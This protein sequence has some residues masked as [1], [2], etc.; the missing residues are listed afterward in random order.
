M[1]RYVGLM[2]GTSLDAIDAALLNL[3]GGTLSLEAH[4]SHPIA[5][6]L[7]NE[8]LALCEGTEGEID[9]AGAADRQL[10]AALG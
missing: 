4:H 9:R 10:G 5:P 6:A 3:D 2:S 8:L 1:P 7:R